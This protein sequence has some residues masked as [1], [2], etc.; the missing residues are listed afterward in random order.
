LEFSS[1]QA[2]WCSPNSYHYEIMDDIRL[3]HRLLL[4]HGV[5]FGP[6][7]PL[8]PMLA[9]IHLHWGGSDCSLNDTQPLK[10]SMSHSSTSLIPILQR[11][12]F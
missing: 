4:Q 9:G 1:L 3:I 8:G 7:L 11:S 12:F 6:L 2:S 10:I 5:K